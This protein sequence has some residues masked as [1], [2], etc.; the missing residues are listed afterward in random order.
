M[1]AVAA[2]EAPTRAVGRPTSFTPETCQAILKNIEAGLPFEDACTDIPNPITYRTFAN[3]RAH[4]LEH[5]ETSPYFQFFQ[6]VQRSET[7][8]KRKHLDRIAAASE[9]DWKASGWIL[10][11]RW[12]EQYAVQSSMRVTVEGSVLHTHVHTLAP[13]DPAQLAGL[14]GY[15]VDGE[16]HE[17]DPE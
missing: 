13:P 17:V 3:W 4:A 12:P 11:H 2:T 7:K 15:T 16:Y 8:A 10:S 1:T 14:L 6:D 9:R 5:G